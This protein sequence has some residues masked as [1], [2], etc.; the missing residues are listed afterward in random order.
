M[1]VAKSNDLKQVIEVKSKAELK[2]VM[3]LLAPQGQ[4][5][6]FEKQCELDKISAALSR[7]NFDV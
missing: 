5:T 7:A 2:Y 4:E 3:N 1:S 6:T